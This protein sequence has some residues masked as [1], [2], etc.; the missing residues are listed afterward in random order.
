MTDEYT[1]TVADDEYTDAF[2]YLESKLVEKQIEVLFGEYAKAIRDEDR[3][4]NVDGIRHIVESMTL[5]EYT[6]CKKRKQ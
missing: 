4:N 1:L 3:D 5:Q 2:R 6:I